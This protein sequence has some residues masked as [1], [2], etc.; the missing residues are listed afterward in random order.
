M[1]NKQTDLEEVIQE[2]EQETPQVEE[3]TPE[4]DLEKF[5]SKDNPDIIKV[6]LSKPPPTNEVEENNT[7][8]TGVA[9]VN[10]DAEPAQSE[11]QVQPERETQ[12]EVQVLEEVKEFK[13][14]VSEA[15][16]QAEATGQPLPEGVQKLVD[17]MADTG[18]SLEDYV[19]LNRDVKDIDDQD[20]LREYY[21]RTKPHLDAE[22]IN[23]L[24]E[25]KFSYDEELDEAKDIKRKKLALKEQVAEAKAYLDGQ[26]SKYY[27]EIKAGSNLTKEQ[28][29]AVDFF[30][31]YNKESEQNQQVITRQRDTFNKKTD[32]LFNDKFKG[33]EYNVGDKVYR[34]NVNDVDQVKETQS[35]INNMFKKFLDENETMSDAKGYHRSLFTAMNADAVAQH[36]YEQ[37]KADAIKENVAK[38]KNINMDPRKSHNSVEAGGIKVRVLGDDSSSYGFK[39]KNKK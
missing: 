9:G 30:N 39:I 32:Q 1:E 14:E 18:G 29:K 16:D 37:G 34:F 33:F 25:D 12:E 5:D 28:Q 23:F 3:V 19:R 21:S 10:E 15:F 35:D 2:V 13:E 24:L 17:F 7:D 26:K 6:D 36:F 4:L 8:D 31:R 11:D 27:E 22:E 38:S 20:A